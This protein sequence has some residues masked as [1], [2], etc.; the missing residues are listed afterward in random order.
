MSQRS[1]QARDALRIKG[2]LTWAAQAV[3]F[4]FACVC[5]EVWPTRMP[6]WA[7]IVALLIALVYI[8][9][10]GK[11]LLGCEIA[12]CSNICTTGMIQAV[13]NRQVGLK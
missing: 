9:P 2:K 10:I 12:C 13:T 11:Y 3:T 6:I 7:L 8:V 5:V 1:R 4:V